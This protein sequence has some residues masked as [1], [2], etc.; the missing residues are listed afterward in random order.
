MNLGHICLKPPLLAPSPFF[1]SLAPFSPCLAFCFH[2]TELLNDSLFFEPISDKMQ[3]VSHLHSARLI[4]AEV[5]NDWT[6]NASKFLFQETWAKFVAK[7]QFSMLNY[8]LISF[9][10]LLPDLWHA[11]ILVKIFIFE[12]LFYEAGNK[13]AFN[14]TNSVIFYSLYFIK[15]CI[16]SYLLHYYDSLQL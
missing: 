3:S 1:L 16:S 9:V 15:H 14:I 7:R 2:V 10:N 4:F 12:C 6:R 8:I 5:E 13:I 11:N